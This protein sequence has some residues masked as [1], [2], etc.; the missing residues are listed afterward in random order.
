MNSIY[1]S[2]N[3][4]ILERRSIFMK[5]N[6]Y[7]IL[8]SGFVLTGCALNP[9]NMHH[10]ASEKGDV[11]I[12]GTTAGIRGIILRNSKS[13]LTYCA[14]P[15]P[16]SA[17]NETEGEKIGATQDGNDSESEGMSE[18]V[19]ESSLGGRSVNVMLTREIFYRTCEFSANSNLSDSDKL[20]LFNASLQAIIKI[21]SQNF[22]NGTNSEA[23]GDAI[24]TQADGSAIATEGA[25]SQ[26]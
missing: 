9:E 10:G 20:A 25:T 12:Y 5:F 21:N 7:T 13:N 22:G 6:L 17:V 4:L 26:P 18:T 19:T 11:E 2:Y 23:A 1:S 15:Q 16:D 8:V 14:E 24:T 3:I